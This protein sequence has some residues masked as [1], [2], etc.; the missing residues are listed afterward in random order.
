MIRV[1]IN[2]DDLGKSAHVNDAI[3]QALADGVISSSTI[4]ANSEN[5]DEV[6]SIVERNPLASFGIHLNLTEGKALTE[7]QVFYKSGIV[8]DSNFFTKK[9]CDLA[10][11][12]PEIRLAIKKEW[13]AQINK[14]KNIEGIDVSH[15]D[16]H[17][18]I[19]T[20]YPL[21]IVLAECLERF[22]ISK[23][24][25]RYHYPRRLFSTLMHKMIAS[26]SYS[27]NA[28][29]LSCRHKSDNTYFKIVYSTLETE[30]WRK[31]IESHFLTTDFFDAY[32]HFCHIAHS[33][34]KND[35]ATIELMCHPGHPDYEAEYKSITNHKLESIFPYKLIS[36]KEL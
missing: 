25:N 32:E 6:H 5:W 12:T 34:D 7:S 19:H 23:I 35:E 3:R 17:H 2:A 29:N 14:V 13:I 15:I 8:D 31:A 1:I 28:F 33:L 16:G 4:M 22:G 36:Y 18:H 26:L 24:R 10:E 30:R 11:Y 20:F 27:E 9:I 21:R